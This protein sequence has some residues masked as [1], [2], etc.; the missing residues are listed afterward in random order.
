MKSRAPRIMSTFSLMLQVFAEEEGP[1]VA[2][3]RITKQLSSLSPI[4]C[5]IYLFTFKLCLLIDCAILES[6]SCA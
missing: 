6:A 2:K 1:S 5:V 4:L 3:I